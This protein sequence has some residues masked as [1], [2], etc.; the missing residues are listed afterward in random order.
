[1]RRQVMSKR[2]GLRVDDG[3]VVRVVVVGGDVGIEDGVGVGRRLRMR[4]ARV[5]MVKWSASMIWVN[6]YWG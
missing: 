1:M 3:W 2:V 4:F 5:W 6:V